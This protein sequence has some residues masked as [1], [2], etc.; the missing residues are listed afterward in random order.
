MPGSRVL[1]FAEI[2]FHPYQ[3]VIVGTCNG[4]LNDNIIFPIFPVQ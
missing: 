4:Q 1:S 3:G 2:G